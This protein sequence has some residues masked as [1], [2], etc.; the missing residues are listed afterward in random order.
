MRPPDRYAWFVPGDLNGFFGLMF[1]NL[2]VLSFL[3]GIL[4]FGF[5]YPADIVFQRMFPGTAF[6]VLAGDLAYV[7]M[8]RRLARASGRKDITAMP[9]GL[10]TPS[11]LGIALVILGPAFLGMKA[12]GIPERE[13]ALATWYLGMATMVLM[14]VAKTVCSFLGSSVQRLVPQAGLLGSL[15][16]LGVALLGFLPLLDIFELPLV[17]LVALGLVFCS[18]VAGIR[19]PWRLPGVLVSVLAGTGLYYAAGPLGLVGGGAPALP[20]LHLHFGLPVPSLLFRHGLGLALRYLPLSIPFGLLTVVGGINVTESA[21]VA[22]DDY[23]TRDV[24]LV[25]ALATILAGL[26]GGVAQTTPYIGHSAYKRM[27]ARCGY[28]LLTGLFIGLGGMLG[29]VSFFVELIPRAVLAPI[30]V[31]VGLDIVVQS[32]QAVPRRHTW[33]VAFAFFPTLARLLAIKFGTPGI[34][35]PAHFQQLM[36]AAGTTLPEMLVTVALGNG[37]ILTAMLWGAFLA[38]L[39]DRRLRRTA[40]YLFLLAALAFFGLV[41]SALPDGAMYL[42]WNLPGWARAVPFQFALGYA[43]LGF[44]VLGLSFSRG[45]LEPGEA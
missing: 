2:S 3:A 6:G 28:A 43:V 39:I 45:S 18:L 15:A 38:E 41:H 8:A 27:G 29:Y 32:F 20:A 14:G 19:M 23:R 31:F 13:A 42:P 7:A 5:G 36:H 30:L 12:Q 34:V 16:G 9:L 44:L 35:D 25:E 37:F 26:C 11:T 33:A 1:D 4:V 17:G 10:D 40:A 24:L 21:R 22:G